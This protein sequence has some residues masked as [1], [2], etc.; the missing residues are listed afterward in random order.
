MRPVLRCGDQRRSTER[1]VVKHAATRTKNTINTLPQHETH[2]QETGEKNRVTEAG[3]AGLQAPEHFQSE[4]SAVV[5][6]SMSQQAL[7]VFLVEGCSG[8]PIGGLELNPVPEV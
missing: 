8:F 6:V 3:P 2:K 7:F 4:V 5:L 1:G